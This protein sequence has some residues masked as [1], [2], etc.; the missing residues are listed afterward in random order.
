ME[1][2]KNCKWQK[3]K[4]FKKKSLYALYSKKRNGFDFVA[5]NQQQPLKVRISCRN[6]ELWNNWTCY[7]SLGVP[8]Q[9]LHACLNNYMLSVTWT[10][11]YEFTKH[12]FLS[13]LSNVTF[14]PE[15]NKNYF[16]NYLFSMIFKIGLLKNVKS[17]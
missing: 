10:V 6:S 14:V 8:R 12:L 15:D 2:G 4:I 11:E 7:I 3:Q 5:Q 17:I 1:T 9:W 13:N 16:L